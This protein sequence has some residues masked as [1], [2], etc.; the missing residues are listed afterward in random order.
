M[1]GAV[2]TCEVGSEVGRMR[3][4]RAQCP[5]WSLKG[6]SVATG[7]EKLCASCKGPSPTRK[8]CDQCVSDLGITG[9]ENPAHGK[10]ARADDEPQADDELTGTPEERLKK[11]HPRVLGAGDR[12]L[13]AAIGSGGAMWLLEDRLIIKHFGLRGFLKQGAFKGELV[14]L[15][16]W[17]TALTFREA[18]S[19]TVGFLQVDYAGSLPMRDPGEGGMFS[20]IT[21]VGTVA[22]EQ[23]DEEQ[24]LKLYRMI[25]SA[26][27]G[28]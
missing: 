23:S 18:G 14:I 2:E 8:Y 4:R 3:F 16:K 28:A 5:A 17:I 26:P 10:S 21:T 12:V 19:V 24:F 6:G 7:T 11:H 1:R 13:A 15:R 25:A 20:E 9:R 27:Q 22:F